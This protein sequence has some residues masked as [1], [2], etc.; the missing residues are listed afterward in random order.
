MANLVLKNLR[1]AE[2]KAGLDLTIADRE[3]VVVAG[4][5]AQ[6][7]SAILRLI[8]GL[9]APLEGEMLFDDRRINDLAPK[10]RD[11]AFL[12]HDYEPYPRLSVY[13]NLAIGLKRRQFA[14]TEIKKRVASVAEAL[15]IQNR[16]QAAAGS[17]S[18][19]ER[20]F[21]GL[22][23][24]MVRQPRI[25]LFDRP[26]ANLD[27][28]DAGRGRAAIA[29]LKQRSSSTII[30]ATDDPSE[31]LAL[32]GRTVIVAGA[33]VQQDAD[34]QTVYDSPANLAV[35]KFFGKPPMNL[36]QGTVK[37]ERDGIAFVEAGEGT[38]SV[39]LPS[40]RFDAA[41]EL[42]GKPAILGFRPESVEIALS[43]GSNRPASG[44]RG[45]VDRV[46]PRGRR[47]DLYLR[48]G[49][50]E[51][52]CRTARWDEGGGRRLQFKIDLEK[53]SLFDGETGFQAAR[54]R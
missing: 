8:A 11:I 35:A 30:Y 7:S 9:A 48:T 51:L 31:A 17:L 6:E 4:P 39:G 52:I 10:D 43:E 15:E 16:L 14:E 29:G 33:A 27:P 45:V 19:A 40:P 46:E 13:E 41:V 2:L 34:A 42:A 3:F 44:F 22:A 12:S 24:V 21:V 20:A 47:A 53:A 49:A 26:F 50:H 37:R 32:G 36:V 23:R 18:R 25:Y 5:N 38:I 54:D 28:L 1:G